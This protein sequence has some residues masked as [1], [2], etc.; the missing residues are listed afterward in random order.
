MSSPFDGRSDDA[1]QVVC[2]RGWGSTLTDHVE[3]R[4]CRWWRHKGADARPFAIRA[5]RRAG[6]TSTNH[7]YIIYLRRFQRGRGG[8]T[9]NDVRITEITGSWH[10]LNLNINTHL[11][12]FFRDLRLEPPCCQATWFWI[13]SSSRETPLYFFYS[14]TQPW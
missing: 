2:R 3:G 12:F 10:I 9:R 7:I 14:W 4:R 8:F 13:L 6:P 5:G 1:G 11:S